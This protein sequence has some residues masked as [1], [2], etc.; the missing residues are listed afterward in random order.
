LRSYHPLR[1]V[2]R[3]CKSVLAALEPEFARM[4]AAKGRP[5]I[6]PERLL[7]AWVLMCLYGVRS[8]RRFSEDLQFNLLYKWFLDMNPDEDGFDASSFSKNL[9]RMRTGT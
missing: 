2:K 3:M 8:C 5:S 1:E 9:G 7:M 4:Y 6:P